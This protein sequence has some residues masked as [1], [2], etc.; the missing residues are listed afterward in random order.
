MKIKNILFIGL[1]SIAKKQ[2]HIL[3]KINQDIKIFK[4][5][6][7]NKKKA[8]DKINELL[9]KF[10]LKNAVICSPANTHLYYINFLKKKN[11]NYLV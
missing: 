3:K 10:K 4:L 11:I 9:E 2:I 8:F 5:K 7:K 6:I 1:G